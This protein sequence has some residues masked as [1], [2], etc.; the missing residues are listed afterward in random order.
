MGKSA[1]QNICGTVC[2]VGRANW[3][4]QAVRWGSRCRDFG[5]KANTLLLVLHW[6]GILAHP[7]DDKALNNC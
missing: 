5:G 4:T 7:G 6:A 3:P 1:H 2:F